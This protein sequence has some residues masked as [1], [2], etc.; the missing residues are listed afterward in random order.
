MTQ[1]TE[2]QEAVM[3]A[4]IRKTI[5]SAR[6]DYSHGGGCMQWL[7]N[8]DDIARTV[9]DDLHCLLVAAEST[10]WKKVEDAK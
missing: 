9:L 5:G 4:V 6:R 3:A 10:E 2:T 8:D 7:G 1:L